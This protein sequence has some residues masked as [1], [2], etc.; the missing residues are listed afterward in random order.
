MKTLK[1]I[2]LALTCLTTGITQAQEAGELRLDSDVGYVN[3]KG[4]G[5]ISAYIG[6]RYNITDYMSAGLKIGGNIIGREV[7]SDLPNY[8]GFT[9]DIGINKYYLGTFDYYFN[10]SGNSFSPYVGGGIGLAQISKLVLDFD[11]VELEFDGGN[12]FG[13][14]IRTGFEVGNFRMGVEY[15]LIPESKLKQ[16]DGDFSGTAP[17]SHLNIHVGYFLGTGW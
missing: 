2:T 16:L 13:G 5:G 11:D 12:K 1:W 8:D 9:V 15:M 7:E 3:I 4:G 14:M 17:N 6:P 10:K